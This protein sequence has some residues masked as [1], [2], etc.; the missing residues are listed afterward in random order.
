[1]ST[2]AIQTPNG[3]NY[4]TAVN[5]GGMGAAADVPIRTDATTIG[6]NE[7]FRLVCA[8]LEGNKFAIQTANGN[9][10][11]FVNKGGIGGPNSNES[12]LHTDAT[13]VK[14]WEKF[15]L[16][17]QGPGKN[18]PGAGSWYAIQTPN[19]KNYLTAVKGG[20]WGES[21]NKYPVHTDAQ[22]AN[23]WEIA[24]LVKA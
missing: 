3:T 4:L 24:T 7:L 14:E 8:D 17:P 12:P 22:W 16:L 5:G 6:P 18:I 13:W 20:G 19:G 23:S 11:T 1:M 10:V 9:F 2:Y 15:R 21:A